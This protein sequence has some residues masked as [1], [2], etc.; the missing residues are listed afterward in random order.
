MK[1]MDER[2]MRNIVDTLFPTHELAK[3]RWWNMLNTE[4]FTFSAEGLKVA[5]GL[6]ARQ[7]GFR[8][9]RSTIGAL[10]KVIEAAMVTQHGSHCSGPVL[11]L[12]TLDVKNAFNSLKWSDVLNTLEHNFSVPHYPFAMISCYLSNRQLEYNTS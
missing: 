11:L 9:G 5:V 12:A 8:P 2:I 1:S 10:W 7:Y 4:L 3:E 6:F